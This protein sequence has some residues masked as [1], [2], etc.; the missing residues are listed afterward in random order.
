[1]LAALAD[2][3][4]VAPQA[5]VKAVAD[6]YNQRVGHGC[7]GDVLSPRAVGAILKSRL[8]LS[9]VKKHG[10]YVVPSSE[11]E[12]VERSLVDTGAT[13]LRKWE[14]HRTWSDSARSALATKI[15]I[16]APTVS[17]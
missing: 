8:R 6:R 17:A 11:R 3:F 4:A 7:E 1:M 16:F 10:V 13:H 12:R 9:T 5:S 14:L 2:V 15:C